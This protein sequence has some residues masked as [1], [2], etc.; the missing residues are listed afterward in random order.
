MCFPPRGIC[1]Q[2]FL[3]AEGKDTVLLLQDF[4]QNEQLEGSFGGYE[5]LASM[6]Y[7]DDSWLLGKVVASYLVVESENIAGCG[8]TLHAPSLPLSSPGARLPELR[9]QNLLSL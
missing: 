4:R 6:S 2:S 3:Y 5:F 9:D 8:P 1:V 7:Q